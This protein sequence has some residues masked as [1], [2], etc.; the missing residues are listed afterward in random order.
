M[1][2][3]ISGKHSSGISGD[4]SAE[5][6]W[7]DDFFVLGLTVSWFWMVVFVCGFG[8]HLLRVEGG[9]AIAPV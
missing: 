1:F 8:M 5:I 6:L 9:L 3:R 4:L 7:V 2:E